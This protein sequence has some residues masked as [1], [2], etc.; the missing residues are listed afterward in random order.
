LYDLLKKDQ[1][2]EWLPRH[3]ISF[4]KIK[5]ILTSEPL[6]HHIRPDR[7]FKITCDGSLRAVGYVLTQRGDDNLWHPVAYGGC[8][9]PKT[10]KACTAAYAEFHALAKCLSDYRHYLGTSRHEILVET[11][12]ANL[13]SLQ[14]LKQDG[15]N[16]LYRMS[17]FL[18]PYPLK[19]IKKKGASNVVADA[20]SRR[21]YPPMVRDE[22]VEDIFPDHEY[23]AM[24]SSSIETGMSQLTVGGPTECLQEVDL[25][26]VHSTDMQGEW[27]SYA[28]SYITD[29]EAETG[30]PQDTM[31]SATDQQTPV[32]EIMSLEDMGPEQKVDP[33]FKF[34]YQWLE[35]QTLSDDPEVARRTMLQADQFILDGDGSLFHLFQ[36]RTRNMHKIK[37]IIQQLVIPVKYRKELLEGVHKSLCHANALRTYVSM[38]QKYFWFGLY[39]DCHTLVAQC[40]ECQCT[41]VSTHK[42]NI[43]I[44]SLQDSPLLGQRYF[45]DTAGPISPPDRSGHCHIL[46]IVH[47]VTR[48]TVAVPLVS[49]TAQAVADALL[50]F[51]L[52]IFGIPGCLHSDR[53]SSFMNE[54]MTHLAKALDIKLQ[55]VAVYRPQANAYV[56]TRNKQMWSCL[57]VLLAEEPNRWG[58]VLGQAA[59]AMNA[60]TM[61][62]GTEMSPYELTFGLLPLLPQDLEFLP[63]DRNLPPDTRAYLTEVTGRIAIMKRIAEENSRENRQQ[64]I[65]NNDS[66]KEFLKFP[67][68]TVVWLKRAKPP[69]GVSHKLVSP[70]HREL[71]V[72]QRPQNLTLTI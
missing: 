52:P 58:D 54:L 35:S 32:C 40:I 7:Q 53:G 24:V 56:E 16:K 37:P 27:T 1:K 13:V 63:K 4:D 20:L 70:Y 26:P 19:F 25:E 68:G 46:L 65:K 43:P 61:V 34:I 57:R 12:S 42:Q 72:I 3:Q 9:L 30:Q 39:N 17:L 60:T 48:F 51:F 49:I 55:Y 67:V 10:A 14:Q 2:W 62:Q 29:Q 18:Q 69:P 45:I 64:R 41:K 23:M 36:N 31:Q 21:A 71:M 15:N 5:Q 47:D 11:D 28:I 22:G 59:F 50:K 6:I 44:R 8:S 38:R 33:E 66:Q